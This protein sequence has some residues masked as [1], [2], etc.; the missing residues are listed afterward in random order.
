MSSKVSLASALAL[1]T[2]LTA[3][4][5][6]AG[7]A[8]RVK[9]FATPV[10]ELRSLPEKQMVE[11]QTGVLFKLSSESE[12]DITLI[13]NHFVWEPHPHFVVPFGPG[14]ISLGPSWKVLADFY[15]E[16]PENYYLG[17]A[18]GPVLEY[19]LGD[20]TAFYLRPMGGF[21]MTNSA[22]EEGD[23]QGQ[24]FTLNYELEVGVRHEVMK[25]VTVSL[26]AYY[27]HFSNWGMSDYNIGYNQ[28]GPMLGVSWSF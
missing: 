3:G 9:D 14:S 26:S 7:E 12:A 21:G 8:E 16:G 5:A 25:D 1:V 18:G 22:G 2:L 20:V 28:G 11:F 13:A 15:A 27:Q 19:W 17:L 23:G 10:V 24:D 6:Y 4:A